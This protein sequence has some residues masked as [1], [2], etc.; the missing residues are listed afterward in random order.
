MKAL[1]PEL[2]RGQMI[3]GNP[4][5]GGAHMAPIKSPDASYLSALKDGGI[6]DL[7][8]LGEVISKGQI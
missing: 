3:S 6:L 7:E 5:K 8:K 1:P 2:P 4:H